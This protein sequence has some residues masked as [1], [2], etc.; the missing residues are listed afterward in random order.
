MEYR[1]RKFSGE[2]LNKLY[3]LL[4]DVTPLSWDCGM[5]CGAACCKG[6]DRDGMILFPGERELFESMSGFSIHHNERYG[7]DV[8][9]CEGVCEREVR[10]LSCRIY[11]YF[12]YVTE[13][14]VRVAPDVRAIR[15]C[16]LVDDKMVLSRTFLR[17]MRMCA[18]V[19][20]MDKNLY[21]FIARLSAIITDF[22]LLTQIY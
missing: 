10:P 2:S 14:F 7:Y 18:E 11:P 13:E 9:V 21:D 6:T 3:E 4:E 22:G 19:I 16:P 15:H 17:R 12:F 5:L 8:L 20:R 1:C